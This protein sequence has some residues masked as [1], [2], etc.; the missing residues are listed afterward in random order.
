[1]SSEIEL[2][3]TASEIQVLR[4]KNLGLSDIEFEAFVSACKRYGLNPLANQ[5]YAQIK[6]KDDPAKRAVSYVAQ[7]DGY[8]LIAD[9]TG[10]YAGNDDP[11]FDNEE[12]PGKATVTVYK[13]VDGVRCPF[14]ASARWKQYLPPFANQQ[15]MWNRMP[16][17]MLGKC[18]EALALRKAFPAELSGLYTAEEMQ[19]AE[20]PLKTEPEAGGD[21]APETQ[22]H[23]P[24]N[25]NGARSYAKRECPKCHKDEPVRKSTTPGQTGFYCWRKVG[26]CGHKWGG[27]PNAAGIQLTTPGDPDSSQGAMSAF[28]K[29][30]ACVVNAVSE[31]DL[32]RIEDRALEV[33]DEFTA[34]QIA[35]LD[36]MICARREALEKAAAA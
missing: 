4:G 19:Q 3:F 34:A 26:G 21:R 17:L 35:A 5:M 2:K 1:M 10:R 30:S 31:A 6:S 20:D 28:S 32:Q 25:G 16:H 15:F 27:D 14:A 8:R 22:T 12:S 9:R 36:K 23:P 33:K 13:V 24:A 11:V 18:A 7:I 29:A